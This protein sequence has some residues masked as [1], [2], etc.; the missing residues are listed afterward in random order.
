MASQQVPQ[1][2]VDQVAEYF[3]ILSEP[4]RLKLLNLLRDREHC[5]QEL[6]EATQTSQAN[7]SKHLKLMLQAG[8]LKRRSEGTSAYYSVK[9][10]LIFELCNLVCDRIASRIEQQARHFRSFSMTGKQLIS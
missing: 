8:I 3:S 7:V 6:V 2:V 10:E 5:V 9:D 1:E 4:M